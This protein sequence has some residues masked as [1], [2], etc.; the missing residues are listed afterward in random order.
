MKTIA[1]WAA[2]KPSRQKRLQQITRWMLTHMT[3][4]MV[5]A[6]LNAP[7]PAPNAS[8]RDRPILWDLLDHTWAGPERE[9]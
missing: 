3:N 7:V 5:V 4:E 2:E 6:Q 9:N 1:D 8:T